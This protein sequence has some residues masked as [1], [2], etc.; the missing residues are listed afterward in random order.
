MALILVVSVYVYFPSQSPRRTG[1]ILMVQ[2]HLSPH[3]LA[4]LLDQVP[5]TIY[6]KYNKYKTGVF[7]KHEC[8]RREQS[9]KFA[10]FSIKVPVKIT[11][12]LTLV[13]FEKV[14]LV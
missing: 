9:P 13:S 10:I 11:R 2:I 1:E 12:S 5:T 14:S 8:P 4:D 7:V 3:I 6:V